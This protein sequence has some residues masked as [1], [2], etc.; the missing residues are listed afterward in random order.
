MTMYAGPTKTKMNPRDREVA[1]FFDPT[2]TVHVVED[3]ERYG[4]TESTRTWVFTTYGVLMEV[5]ESDEFRHGWD[6]PRLLGYFRCIGTVHADGRIEGE[7]PDRK[8][9]HWVAK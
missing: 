3:T 6:G 1:E 4:N 9:P 8:L 2:L 7:V 5:G